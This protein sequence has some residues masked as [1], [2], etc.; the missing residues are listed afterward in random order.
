MKKMVEAGGMVYYLGEEIHF[1]KLFGSEI[2]FDIKNE[3][4]PPYC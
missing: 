1:G 3:N 2:A 4:I